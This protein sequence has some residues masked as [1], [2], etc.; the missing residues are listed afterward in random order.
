MSKP[1]ARVDILSA[2]PIRQLA[3]ERKF[4]A[5]LERVIDAFTVSDQLTK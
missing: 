4:S 3:I 2:T 1:N 5:S